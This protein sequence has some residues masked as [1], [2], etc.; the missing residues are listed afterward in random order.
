MCIYIYIYIH[1][2]IHISGELPRLT[3]LFRKL[4]FACSL[5]CSILC[6]AISNQFYVAGSRLNPFRMSRLCPF[7]NPHGHIDPPRDSEKGPENLSENLP[8]KRRRTT[9]G[10]KTITKVVRGGFRG[11]VRGG[12]RSP[13]VGGLVLGP[14]VI[15]HTT[16]N[17]WQVSMGLLVLICRCLAQ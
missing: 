6:V 12:F 4:C 5:S 10:R 15:S 2:C 13:C 17:H 16:F 8:Q 7:P 9:L 11:G 14:L 1:I 3:N